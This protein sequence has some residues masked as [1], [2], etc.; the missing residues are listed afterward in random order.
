MV[1]K[2]HKVGGLIFIILFSLCAVVVSIDGCISKQ[3]KEIMRLLH[4]PLPELK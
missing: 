1:K 4:T 2:S 3:A